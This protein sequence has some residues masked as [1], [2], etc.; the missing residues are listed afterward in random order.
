MDLATG[1]V[2]TEGWTDS[3]ASDLLVLGGTDGLTHTGN[4]SV[5]GVV[6]VAATAL[7]D[8]GLYVAPTGLTGSSQW[9]AV[10]TV[11]GTTGATTT[12]EGVYA[13]AT[14]AASGTVPQAMDFHA[15]GV[16]RSGTAVITNAYGMLVEAIS[17]SATNNY[18]VY[19]KTPTGGSTTN[20]GVYVAGGGV[21]IA[22]GGLYVNDG[23]TVNTGSIALGSNSVVSSSA[24][25]RN[26]IAS[27]VVT[28]GSVANNTATNVTVNFGF[29]FST[30]PDVLLSIS[31]GSDLSTINLWGVSRQS[32]FANNFSVQFLNRTGS[33]QSLFAN[34]IAI[35]GA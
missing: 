25:G 20:I 9:G 18:G 1:A 34:W 22:A 16:V 2:I 13:T 30:V 7:G 6:G 24:A 26:K 5:T 3:V 11:T 4:Y 19:V 8:R 15:A 27:G 32:I 17:G 28:S 29:T 23:I 12:L 35:G 14:T 33:T 10:V 21:T 31:D